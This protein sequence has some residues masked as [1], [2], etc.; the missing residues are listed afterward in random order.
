M[1]ITNSVKSWIPTVHFFLF[2]GIRGTKRG[3]PFDTYTKFCCRCRFQPWSIPIQSDNFIAQ[4]LYVSWVVDGNG[5][6]HEEII[7]FTSRTNDMETTGRN[8]TDAKGHWRGMLR[9]SRF[10][11]N[12][13]TPTRPAGG[14]KREH[15]PVN[16]Y[17]FQVNNRDSRKRCGICLKLTIKTPEQ[18]H[19]RRSGVFIVNF[20]HIS[21][22]FLVFLL[23]TLNK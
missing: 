4:I 8:P 2:S 9:L 10:N 12:A 22:F 5:Y 15:Y 19:W 23:L 11:H 7:E 21:H 16:I 18:C 17:L 14:L 13:L 6:T 20:K 1:L 3:R